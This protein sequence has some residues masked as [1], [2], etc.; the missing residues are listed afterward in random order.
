MESRE[1]LPSLTGLRGFTA[2]WVLGFHL[3][4]LAP[5]IGPLFRSGYLGVDVFFV[6]SGFILVHN[7]R[8]VSLGEWLPFLRNRVAR[9]V[10]VHMAALILMVGVVAA[11]GPEAIYRSNY[12][13]ECLAL[14]ATL[15]QGWQF[16]IRGCW[17][18]P[19]WSISCEWLMYLLFPLILRVRGGVPLVAVL[20]L[21]LAV[22]VATGDFK[23]AM[24]P[25]LARAVVEF[26]A[27]AIIYR[28]WASGTV[29]LHGGFWLGLLVVGSVLLDNMANSHRSL[30]VFPVVACLAVYAIA[31]SKLLTSAAMDYLGRISYC[32]YMVH[33]P[34]VIV[35]RS[36]DM[37]P[38]SAL[39]VFAL[40][41]TL[42]AVAYHWIEVPARRALLA[43]GKGTQ[44]GTGEQSPVHT[45][46]R[47]Q[48]STRSPAS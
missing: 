31:G 33:W 20:F 13:R 34:I 24:Q 11:L 39:P 4:P 15:T 44:F 48:P 25:G 21:V 47:K 37:G 27:G 43:T 35:A 45:T 9:I 28:L 30:A 17:N 26:T 7:Y 8:V 41:V 42:A 23:S 36:L 32:L 10:P 38:W 46:Q 29:R 1:Y 2:L 14:S 19:A 6:L 18:V 12:T 22:I 40:S 3:I 16:P 5:A